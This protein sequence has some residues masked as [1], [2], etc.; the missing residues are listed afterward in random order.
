LK[1][2]GSLLPD[3]LDLGPFGVNVTA[4]LINSNNECWGETFFFPIKDTDDS[5]KAK[6]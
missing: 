4:Q 3:P 6:E 2:K 5:Y 1:G